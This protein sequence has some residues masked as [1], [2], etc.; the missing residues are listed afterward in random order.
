MYKLI[1]QYNHH[2]YMEN[3]AAQQFVVCR[4]F[5]FQEIQNHFMT[6]FFCVS[7]TSGKVQV[8]KNLNIDFWY[9]LSPFLIQL[10]FIQSTAF[11]VVAVTCQTICWTPRQEIER[12]L[13]TKMFLS[14]KRN[15]VLS[16]FLPAVSPHLQGL[17]LVS[18]I[19]PPSVNSH[20][21][22]EHFMQQSQRHSVPLGIRYL[23]R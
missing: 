14:M 21:N 8:L 23:K 20:T 4:Y 10:T 9:F 1:E 2:F 19:F 18:V 15:T 3:T 7:V 6:S 5:S 17:Q 11:R 13:K 16:G 12:H 22:K